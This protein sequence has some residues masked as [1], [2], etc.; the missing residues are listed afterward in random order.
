MLFPQTYQVQD[1]R[2]AKSSLVTVHLHTFSIISAFHAGDFGPSLPL[3]PNVP[4]HLPVMG[5]ALHVFD[6]MTMA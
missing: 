5:Q 4:R 6:H 3:S 1:K 2:K